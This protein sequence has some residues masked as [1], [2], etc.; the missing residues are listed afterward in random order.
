MPV[1]LQA[2]RRGL[3]AGVSSIALL[4]S[5]QSSA[6]QTARPADPGWPREIAAQGATLTYYQPQLD[7]WKDY[8]EVSAR[9]A[10][11]LAPREATPVV[12]VA[13]VK[14][15]TQADLDARV[16]VVKSIE[17]IE[18]RF[19]SLDSARVQPMDRLFRQLFPTAGMT[20]SLD[21][22]LAALQQGKR[23]QAGPRP[24]RQRVITGVRGEHQLAAVLRGQGRAVLLARR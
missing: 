24:G 17:V 16:V 7:G 19:P 3:L 10:F 6:A 23:R 22:V 21:R 5:V 15:K 2:T 14:A 1:L 4:A 13:S 9:V 8:K 20:V 18:T 12:G 11:S